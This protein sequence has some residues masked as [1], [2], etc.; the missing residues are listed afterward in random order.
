MDDIQSLIGKLKDKD[1]HVRCLAIHELEQTQDKRAI[2]PLI[3]ML[4]DR[5]SAVRKRAVDALG[6]V[7]DS[8]VVDPLIK[9]LDDNDADVRL[10][11]VYALAALGDNLAVDPL[12]AALKDTDKRVRRGAAKVLGSMGDDRA[13]APLVKLVESAQ[14]D[15]HDLAI[16][17]L[18]QLGNKGIEALVRLLKVQDENIRLDVARALARIGD[19]R[20]I[21][22]LVASFAAV[23]PTLLGAALSPTTFTILAL[24]QLGDK[25][26][27]PLQA[28]LDDENRNVRYWAATSLGYITDERAMSALASRL[29]HEDDPVVQRGIADALRQIGTPDA[30]AAAKEWEQK[31]G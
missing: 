7:G 27:D 9:T 20:A 26:I 22:P 5:E 18:S 3:A 31:N 4:H 25:V 2:E 30:L 16:Q 10:S 13:I 14:T 29:R 15:M 28:A 23:N 1:Q 17:A 19:T 21:E 12:I 24:R 8:R 11:V 6:K